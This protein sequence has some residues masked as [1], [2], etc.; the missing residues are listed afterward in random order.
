MLTKGK[1]QFGKFNSIVSVLMFESGQ[2]VSAGMKGQTVFLVAGV[3]NLESKAPGTH[4]PFPG[5]TSSG[6]S[7]TKTHFLIHRFP[8]APP[9][10]TSLEHTVL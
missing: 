1:G 5:H 4:S 8:G 9:W 6:L 3:K 10:G 7:L 2:Q